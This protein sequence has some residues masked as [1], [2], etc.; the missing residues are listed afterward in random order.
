MF[1][2]GA[3]LALTIGVQLIPIGQQAVVHSIG[4]MFTLA[5]LTIMVTMKIRR[6]AVYATV[7]LLAAMAGVAFGLSAEVYLVG[8]GAAVTVTGAVMLW[9][10]TRKHR[11]IPPEEHHAAT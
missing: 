4:L 8:I 6:F 11:A 1:L 10:F 9:R 3:A 5:M 7:L 2:A